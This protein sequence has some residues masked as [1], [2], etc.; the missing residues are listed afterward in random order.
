MQFGEFESSSSHYFSQ[1]RI[2]HRFFFFREIEESKPEVL[3]SLYDDVFTPFR[4]CFPFDE[5]SLEKIEEQLRGKLY[6][7]CLKRTTDQKE[8]GR[9]SMP[10]I[11]KL[12]NEYYW[13]IFDAANDK[14]HQ[15]LIPLREAVRQW[16][17]KQNLDAD[18]CRALV[19]DSMRW[20]G[21][22]ERLRWQLTTAGSAYIDHQ[23]EK[24]FLPCPNFPAWSPF[25]QRK[26]DYLERLKETI[27]KSI[28]VFY[29]TH[30][31]FSGLPEK[32]KQRTVKDIYREGEIYCN[33]L[34]ALYEDKG[35]TQIKLSRE[36]GR[37]I[38]WAVLAQ[39]GTNPMMLSQIARKYR[40]AVHHVS[41]DV[42]ACLQEINLPVR[43]TLFGSGRR[44]GIKENKR[45]NV[46]HS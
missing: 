35:Y 14:Y 4:S 44:I 28:D 33:K 8:I 24:S 22:A 31:L 34:I 29:S 10:F 3:Q 16:T 23:L 46:A 11:S 27:T 6:N 41:E 7:E 20:F 2:R 5:T 13:T 37:K 17:K 39:V 40:I 1:K 12:H 38:R 15:E 36:E 43:D 19:L 25:W 45:R 30:P 26:S 9:L 32:I 21:K 42:R 18:W